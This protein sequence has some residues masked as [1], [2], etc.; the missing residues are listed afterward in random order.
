MT[1]RSFDVPLSKLS[2]DRVNVRK[3]DI[4]PSQ[5]FISSLKEKGQIE[6][7]IVR[8][9]GKSDKYLI[10][11]GGMRFRAFQQ[12]LKDKSIAA[13]HP[14]HVIVRE[15]SDGDA[16][17]TSLATSIVRRR[18]HPVDEL[19]AFV[20]LDLPAAD[21]AKRYG[22]KEKDVLKVLA[23]GGLAKP[24]RDAWRDGKIREDDAQAFTLQPDLKE[25][26]A[27]FN[28]L[29]KA[30]RLWGNLITASIVGGDDGALSAQLLALVGQK[31]YEAAG[32]KVNRSLFDDGDIAVSDKPLLKTLADA[33]LKKRCDALTA[34]G[35]GWA[36]AVQPYGSLPSE[37]R[38]QWGPYGKADMKPDAKKGV[39]IEI[40]HKGSISY[41]YGAM[42][43][44]SRAAAEKKAK[45]KKAGGGK[46][47]PVLSN[48]L[49]LR[50]SE[51][52]TK[53]A[54]NAICEVDHKIALAAL[55]AGFACAQ[56]NSPVKVDDNG[57][58]LGRKSYQPK[59]RTG[60]FSAEFEAAKKLKLEKQL[61]Q[62]ALIVGRSLDLRVMDKFHGGDKAN[63]E[64]KALVESLGASF[65]AQAQKAFDAK[66]YFSSISKTLALKAIEEA[67]SKDQAQKLASKKS[68]EIAAFAL[69]NVPKTGWLPP[70]LR[71]AAYKAKR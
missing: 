1:I 14:V 52:G 2:L 15:E 61:D 56:F 27:L 62:L 19:E 28:R 34:K 37:A 32:G 66:D 6:P 13:D 25:Q 58:E 64:S 39:I 9:D 4:E 31:D 18:L 33:A 44:Q 20:A 54:A 51:Q 60:K 3:T 63:I 23:L 12:L 10:V 57:Y 22:M 68:A 41:H 16:V 53:A 7:L 67:V 42:K 36:D 65:I 30:G 59:N 69:A 5:A 26:E 48:A 45:A 24:I 21:I 70:Q 46:A 55:I 29:K 47:A 71:N 17:D 38:W 40:D 11:N 50:L 35:W 49:A 43:P 8:P